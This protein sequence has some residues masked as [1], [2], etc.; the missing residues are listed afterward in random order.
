MMTANK[1]LLEWRNVIV[2]IAVTI[3]VACACASQRNVFAAHNRYTIIEFRGTSEFPHGN[4]RFFG[5]TPS[6]R[7]QFAT[8]TS[9][10]SS[11]EYTLVSDNQ[12]NS[13]YLYT[14]RPLWRV[15]SGGIDENWETLW[16][17]D[18]SGVQEFSDRGGKVDCESSDMWSSANIR[19]VYLDLF[20]LPVNKSLAIQL[21][22][23]EKLAEGFDFGATQT[24][25]DGSYQTQRL[26]SSSD[27]VVINTS[28]AGQLLYALTA[29][30]LPDNASA[31]SCK[32]IL[33]W[34]A[35]PME[36][37]TGVLSVRRANALPDTIQ[38]MQHVEKKNHDDSHVPSREVAREE[39][40]EQQSRP[41][42]SRWSL[43]VLVLGCVSLFM[44]FV[45]RSVQ[46][47]REA[48]K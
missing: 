41:A 43:V 5:D 46:G 48:K 40:E 16:H 1:A 32:V 33:Y 17:Q 29:A 34:D 47:Q 24:S 26:V 18:E 37:M 21:E 35:K 27:E 2:L 20:G 6:D 12:G 39:L 45:F 7:Q 19:S 14:R 13:L 10:K 22:R 8:G 3:Y 11:F 25:T 36:T 9:S 44:V 38:R 31:A 30:K 15:D 23:V 42:E 4:Q 28:L